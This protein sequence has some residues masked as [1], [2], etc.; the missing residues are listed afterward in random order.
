[1]KILAI[2]FKNLN[3]LVGEWRIDLRH[4]DYEEQ[5]LF[6]ITGPTG[7]GKS[8]ILDAVCLA[9][10][11][12]T[13]RLAN[14]KK[15]GNEIMSRQTGE[16]FA[17]VLFATGEGEFRCHWSQ[18]RARKKPSGALQ[19]QRHELTCGDRVLESSI[20]GVARKVE[21]LT[22][23]DFARFTRAVL[24]A[25]GDFAAFL[26]SSA[27]ER[28]SL[29]EKITGTEIYSRISMRVHERCS[30]ARQ[31]LE[32]LRDGIEGMKL[33]APEQE[34]RCRQELAGALR[35][36]TELQRL[37]E[38]VQ[39]AL[40][41]R[42]AL[43]SCR[44][45]VCRKEE[46]LKRLERERADLEPLAVR[47][48]RDAAARQCLENM[49]DAAR[50]RESLNRQ[51]AACA[52]E[53][54]ACDALD[55]AVQEGQGSVARAEAAAVQLRAEA[56][57]RLPLLQKALHQDALIALQE[58]Q[59]QEAQEH[60]DAAQTLSAERQDA[61]REIAAQQETLARCQEEN[62][63]AMRASA[64]DADLPQ[65]MPLIRQTC[66][67]VAER[68]ARWLE[69]RAQLDTAGQDATLAEQGVLHARRQREEAAGRQERERRARAALEY[70]I[71]VLLEEKD[72]DAWQEE[73]RRLADRLH[74]LE[75]WERL[76]GDLAAA[77]QRRA[78]C[79]QRRQELVAR[80]DAQIG[81]L[82]RETER[83]EALQR[84]EALLKE[85]YMQQRAISTYAQARR[86]L[87]D[88]SPCPLCGALE[89]PYADGVKAEPD[90]ARQRMEA[91]GERVRQRREAMVA[92]QTALA[93]LDE[94]LQQTASDIR[95]N[96]RQEEQARTRIHAVATA[97]FD[98]MP[99]FAN[100]AVSGQ[101][102]ANET[103]RCRQRQ[104]YCR[105]LLQAWRAKMAQTQAVEA[106]VR[107]ADEAL[108]QAVLAENT[109]EIRLQAALNE[110]QRRSREQDESRAALEQARREC[111]RA[112]ARYDARP[113]FVPELLDELVQRLEGRAQYRLEVVRRAES[114]RQEALLLEQKKRH[115]G[116]LCAEAA[117]G[118]R[119]H[120][121]LLQEAAEQMRHLREARAALAVG[122]RPEE[123]G[124]N[125]NRAMR[126]AEQSLEE[127]RLRQADAEQRRLVTRNHLE[128]LRKTLEDSRRAC[129]AADESLHACLRARNFDLE[130]DAQRALLTEEE[131]RD[132][133]ERLEALHM[134]EGALR[135]GL[136]QARRLLADTRQRNATPLDIPALRIQIEGVQES[137]R[138]VQQRIGGCR[139]TL[140]AAE[141]QREQQGKAAEELA[142][143]TREWQRWQELD[144]LIGASEG[145]TYR[146]F[147]QE[148]TFEQLLIHAN[149]RLRDLSDR[150]VLCP[151]PARHLEL[152]VMDNYQAGERRS[153]KN[154]SGGETFLVSLALALGLSRMTGHSIKIE[155][156][157]LDEGF[158]TLDE[159]AL[160]AALSVL[161]RLRQEG[162]L[163]GIISHVPALREL[164]SAQ[165]A[166]IP[167]AGGRSR[168][169]GAGC[170]GGE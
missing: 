150:Y 105:N 32:T 166:V 126:E 59:V 23:M 28:S 5:G 115:F 47:L 6:A 46:A 10:Y 72:A 64:D 70:D 119:R 24:L 49:R 67:L 92:M 51:E 57:R 120:A 117:A 91:Q 114:L 127:A 95:E 136:E 29:L 139:Q 154:L 169:Q 22:G 146:Q 50:C 65:D 82:E 94:Q 151:D 109:A 2:R 44:E 33:I 61:L 62:D 113:D 16:C 15:S 40:R 45:E 11:G 37:A 78:Q 140:D 38:S 144:S 9:L 77:T 107:Q 133:K 30:R 116:D 135:M 147:V 43:R 132:W 152:L 103:A 87:H 142:A 102:L 56:A 90:A 106:A 25:Q 168:L 19:D 108:A 8:T 93:R 157:F 63:A 104:T 85:L 129:H 155:S 111:A 39:E 163:I 128:S 143:R 21:E 80:R 4:P 121:A 31:E 81:L 160:D 26:Q 54:L 161:S 167:E 58:R 27:N 13:P 83:L 74:R 148:L 12:R 14:V 7:A 164:I 73:E 20:A 41:W 60:L 42:E 100:D 52:A 71:K 125:L 34:D 98:G 118:C 36:E 162:T 158:G 48:E 76:R 18:R 1:M 123:E 156:L 138:L 141:Q 97:C 170:C 88:G 101:E 159:D 96:R 89:H 149:R 84:E 153:A 35:A 3:S 134:Q 99:A 112:L 131:R 122:P 110:R 145:K 75:E 69:A 17:E 55:R 137:L 66:A 68:R 165:I 124:E 79:E 53:S 130:E 86:H